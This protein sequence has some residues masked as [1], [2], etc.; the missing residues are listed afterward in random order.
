M[1]NTLPKF[2]KGNGPETAGYI[3]YGLP[4]TFELKSSLWFNNPDMRDLPNG[5]MAFQIGRVA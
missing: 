4:R 3:V 5:R 2:H 1:T